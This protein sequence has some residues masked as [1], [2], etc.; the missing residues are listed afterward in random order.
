MPKELLSC[1]LTDD[2]N[3]KSG[4]VSVAVALLGKYNK[5]NSGVLDSYLCS[6]GTCNRRALLARSFVSFA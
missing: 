5:D 3:S 1:S 6:G 4:V 2:S